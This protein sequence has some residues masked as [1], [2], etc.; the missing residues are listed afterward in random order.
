MYRKTSELADVV[1]GFYR[2]LPHGTV[3]QFSGQF[4]Q[5]VEEY[6]WEIRKKQ[7]EI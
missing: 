7:Q 2:D 1:N 6:N 3:K 5:T 4:E